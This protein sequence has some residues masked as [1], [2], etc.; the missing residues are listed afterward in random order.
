M[1]AGDAVAVERVVARALGL[2]V[3]DV[4]DALHYQSVAAWD[5]FAHVALMVEL[6]EELGEAIDDDLVLRLRS[7]AAIREYARTRRAPVRAAQEPVVRRGLDGVVVDESTITRIDADAGI[8]EYRGYALADLAEHACFEEVAWLLLHGDLPDAARLGRFTADLAGRRALPPEVASL[9]RALAGAHPM[10]ALRTGVSALGALRAQRGDESA[11]D[12]LDAGLDLIAQVPALVAAHHAARSGRAPAPLGASGGH[13][14]AFLRALLGTE[15]DERDVAF[16][17]RDLVVHADHESNA[18]A[19]AARVAIGCRTTLHAAVTAALAAFAGPLHGGAAERV[20][21]LVDEVGDPAAARAYVE[22]RMARG[23]AVPGFGHRVYRGTDPRVEPLRDAALELGRRR[24][25]LRAFEVVEAVAEAMR[26]YE[27]HGVG[28]N[29][30]LYAGIAYRLLG[31][32]D[33]LAVPLFAAGRTAGWVAQSLEQKRD[34]VLIRPL[35]RYVGEPSRP[36]PPLGA[37]VES[38]AALVD[39][40]GLAEHVPSADLADGSLAYHAVHAGTTPVPFGVLLDAIASR[41]WLRPPRTGHLGDWRDIAHGR[42]GATDFNQAACGPGGARALVHALTQTEAGIDPRGGGDWVY[43]PGSVI[44]D[45]RRRALDLHTWDGR[46]FALRDRSRPLLCPF[47]R[48]PRDGALV[49]LVTLHADRLA[50]L[51]MTSAVEAAV[52]LQD[53]PRVR[54]MLVALLD[55]AAARSESR[56]ALRDLV[57]GVVALDGTVTAADPATVSGGLRI[58]GR[59]YAEASEVADEAL[60]VL[61]AAA[62]PETVHDRMGDLPAALP[63]LSGT[64]L[65]LLSAALATHCPDPAARAAAS[66]PFVVH[67][68]WGARHMAGYPPLRRGYLTERSTRRTLTAMAGALVHA[69]LARPVCIVLL[70]AAAF[71]LCPTSAHPQDADLVAALIASAGEGDDALVAARRWIERHGDGLSAYFRGRFGSG[72]PPPPGATTPVMP[73]GLRE[74]PTDRLCA[75][76]AALHEAAA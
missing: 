21:R 19:F 40:F 2:S 50:G 9:M 71:L 25:D 30:D 35:L 62:E 33:D 4:T 17:D 53:A 34:N 69:E 44:E 55:A 72:A 38:G 60:L 24:G 70:P 64:A 26:P 37:R 3:E 41:P 59:T 73:E 46:G 39:A 36:F 67:P 45:G 48:V 63:L 61:R 28:A 18:S 52:L 16:L 29:V 42:S 47:V 66:V 14:A 65:T 51:P 1:G 13:A 68:H 22:E 15:P 58:G 27:R 8:L 7:V 10:D 32:P 31:L 5:S 74:A 11:E 49:P 76:V 23:D 75:I 43:R 6:E 54:S 20:V 56:R 57:T 12:A